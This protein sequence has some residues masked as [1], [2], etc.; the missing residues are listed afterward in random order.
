MA[1]ISNLAAKLVF[2]DNVTRDE[3]IN[4]WDEQQTGKLTPIMMDQRLVTPFSEALQAIEPDIVVCD[5]ATGFG[6]EAADLLQIPIVV[7]VSCPWRLGSMLYDLKT[8]LP[9]RGDMCCGCYCVRPTYMDAT[10]WCYHRWNLGKALSRFYKSQISRK[11]ISTTFFGFEK[12][13]H[14]PPN[15]HL[16]GPH[17][18]E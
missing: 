3:M 17:L 15:V 5:F 2:P 7:L 8:D 4:G 14:L 10:L 16:T 1:Q 12:V 11:L 6:A 18:P 13:E 9:E